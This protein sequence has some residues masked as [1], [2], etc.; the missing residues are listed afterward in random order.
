MAGEGMAKG[1][2]EGKWGGMDLENILI[3]EKRQTNFI[4]KS[5]MK[6]TSSERKHIG[7]GKR[8]SFRSGPVSLG[9]LL[10]YNIHASYG[11]SRK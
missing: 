2:E 5:C 6:Y 7:M 3:L 10:Q 8:A 1:K 11:W 4:T 9:G